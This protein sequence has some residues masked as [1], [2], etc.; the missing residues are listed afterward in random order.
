M[1]GNDIIYQDACS[2]DEVAGHLS[3]NLEIAKRSNLKFAIIH[4]VR[5]SA[6]W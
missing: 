4:F 1:M 6:G 5:Q 3:L 2:L